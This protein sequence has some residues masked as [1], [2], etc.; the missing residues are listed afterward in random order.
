MAD[1]IK[2]PYVEQVRNPS[3]EWFLTPDARR[4]LDLCRRLDRIIELLE[5]LT[6]TAP[7]TTARDEI[8]TVSESTERITDETV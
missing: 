2:A 1:T 4:H 8:K 7:A 3:G 5:A 6:T